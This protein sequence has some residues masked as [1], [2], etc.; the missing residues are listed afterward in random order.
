MLI[1]SVEFVLSSDALKSCPK[2]DKPEYAFLGRSNVGKSSLMNM[3]FGN[4]KLV[5]TSSTPGKTQLMNYFLVNNHM[6][7]VDLPGYGFAKSSKTNRLKW[8]EM[9]SNYFQKRES[10]LNSFLVIDS[11]IPPQQSDLETMEWFATKQLPF[12]LVFTKTDKLSKRILAKNISDYKI[13]LFENWEE[14]PQTFLSSKF[15]EG[16]E[17][18]LSY[19]ESINPV[20]NS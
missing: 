17:E 14:L 3:L 15:G 2:P 20:F 7:F 5:K 19:I 4:K 6:Y 8:A 13:K 1:K 9:T 18:I 12:S 11:R 16:K 10:L